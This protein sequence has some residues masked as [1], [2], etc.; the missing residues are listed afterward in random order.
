MNQV[1]LSTSSPDYQSAIGDFRYER[2]TDS[3][4]LDTVAQMRISDVESG[5]FV[6]YVGKQLRQSERLSD[7]NKCKKGFEKKLR[8]FGYHE[9]ADRLK[10]CSANYTS[11]VCDNGH[12]FRPIVDYRCH[13]PF[14]PDCWETKAIRE[15]GRSLPR[16]LQALK[17]DP[18]LIIALF[19]PTIKSDNARGLR[20]GSREIKCEFKK[21]RERDVW[22][23]CVGG[24]GRIENTYSRKFGWH[25]HLHALILLKD[26]IP[27]KRLSDAWK[28]ITKGNS[29]VVDIREVKDVAKGLV[30]TIK[31]PFKPADLS[32]LGQEQIQEML[33]LKGE[34]LGVSFGV[35]FGLEIEEE[36]EQQ[37]LGEYSEFIEETRKLEIGDSCPIC[38]SRLDLVDFSRDGYMQ[39][40]GSV[41]LLMGNR[42]H[43][44]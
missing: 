24:F 43:P 17:N 19:T 33:N 35:L 41:P 25:P 2:S 11:L 32:K 6:R 36:I 18:S 20:S 26:Y 39:F 38:H 15:M 9:E 14:C 16:F 21:L 10:R 40:L 12:S 7:R 1:P 37:M 4:S 42:G 5:I 3:F 30:E 31:Y 23:N 34:R 28:S 13:L 27:Q 22:K 44:N 8:K 29:M